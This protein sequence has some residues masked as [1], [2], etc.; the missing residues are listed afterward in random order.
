MA[1]FQRVAHAC[2]LLAVLSLTVA[3][4][5][6]Y[7]VAVIMVSE[8]EEN[9]F[10][11]QRIGPAID[12]AAEEK[13]RTDYATHLKIIE[14]YYPKRCSER[15]AIGRAT[16]LLA[17][18]TR[19]AA[20]VGPSCSS[21]LNIVERYANYRQI[22][23]VTGLGDSFERKPNQSSTLIR[24]SYV[25][26]DKARAILA[27]LGHFQWTH[28]GI[29]YRDRNIYY[30]TLYNEL[31]DLAEG[32]NMTVTCKRHFLRDDKTKMVLSDLR[33]IMADIKRCAR[34][35][36]LLSGEKEVRTMLEHAQ[37][38]GMT[39]SGEY[40]FLYS[41]LFQSEAAGNI[42]WSTGV[43]DARRRERLRKAFESLL[44]IS[45]NQ[46]VSEEYLRFS[47]E[48]KRRSRKKYSF[49]GDMEQVVNYFTASFHDAVVMLCKAINETVTVGLDPYAGVNL[50]N[51]MRN[52]NISGVSGRVVIDNNGDRIADYAL[53]DQV[54]PQTG[55]FDVV[56]KY[57]GANQSYQLVNDI[58]WPG[59]GPPVDVPFCGFDGKD[60]KCLKTDD[61]PFIE[62]IVISVLVFI[63]VILICAFLV[64]RK[65]QLESAI[66]NMSWRIKWEE[67]TFT[68][69]QRSSWMMSRLSITSA[70]AFLEAGSKANEQQFS[71]TG[72]FK[73]TI[74]SVKRLHHQKR[75]E[76]T[77]NVLIEL[78]QM[79]ET[80]HE[81]IARFVG[82]C[83]DVPNIAILTEYCPKGSLQDVLHND[84]LRLEWLFRY[85]L[86]NDIVKGMTYLHGTEI[87]SHGR[88][89]SSNCVVD[90][91][92]VL[93]LTDFGLPTFR[94]D[95]TYVPYVIEGSQK[96]LWKAPELLRLKHCSPTGTQKGDVY[97]FGIILQEIILREDAFYP[98]CDHLETS[99]IVARVITPEDPPFRP[100]V[101]RD[102]CISE[103]HQLMTRCWA[104]D[105]DE[106]PTFNHIK[107]MMRVINRGYHG[108]V[109]IMDNI[110]ARME[111]YA[112]E[113]EVLV[114][115]RTAAFLEEKRKSEELLYQVLPRSVAEQLKR[116][117]AV[118][119]ELYD[120]VTIYFSDIV[121][122]TSMCSSSTPIQVVDFLND[123]YTCFDAVISD[124]DVYKVETI[125]DAY[126]VVSGLPDRNGHNHARE[127]ARMA[128]SLLRAVRNFRIRHRPD[129]TLKLRIGMH[130]GPCCAGV[131]G[132][133]MPRYCLFG[134]TVNTASRMESNGEPLR[135][136]VS[137]DTKAVLERFGTF[138][139]QPRGGIDIKGKGLMHT[140]WLLG[141]HSKDVLLHDGI[142]KVMI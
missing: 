95:E 85:S 97:S 18:V 129:D 35:V 46:P 56:L 60:P 61:F 136:H 30:E 50:V 125:G 49:T 48:V 123:L 47:N 91:H 31:A 51:R 77:R 90:S 53:L 13:C 104:E 137:P 28:F 67:I 22:P 131:V 68:R 20:F 57:F 113:L 76:L 1:Q 94:K 115:Q 55:H 26:R 114:E 96:Y 89:R 88:L 117:N 130:T 109:N 127:V 83:I 21:D 2:L 79:R 74:V 34:I 140:F 32:V 100:V 16:D 12:I 62:T 98:H 93:K 71:L 122:F 41:E 9:R 15:Y 6:E 121:G 73:G 126:M 87:G 7:T 119:P 64:Y 128:L 3:S 75:I 72:A 59:K 24:T 141:E 120:S 23:V 133:K 63:V 37:D 19:V 86:I 8:S 103:L 42:S 40:A 116:G 44:I 135:I 105:P 112:N 82:A 99:D 43:D 5:V 38:L 84:S 92:F 4:P 66:A 58:H 54:D 108:E 118:I 69:N 111:Q 132:Q 80:Q 124:F 110:M 29:V 33:T 101:D 142:K 65:M 10:D 78:K 45:L 102:A 27:F 52:A 39:S 25:L 81:N 36:V 138:H 70:S 17:A 134:D 107:V 106:R 11:I 139:L 14:A